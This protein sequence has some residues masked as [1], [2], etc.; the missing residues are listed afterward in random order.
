MNS[1]K[2][3]V[4]NFSGSGPSCSINFSPPT[5]SGPGDPTTA[6]WSSS[7]DADNQIP[8]SCTGNISPG[9]LTTGGSLVVNPT[10][11]QTCTLTVQNSS[12]SNTCQGSVTVGS[13]PTEGAININLNPSSGGPGSS[14]VAAVFGQC[15]GGNEVNV[16]VSPSAGSCGSGS[17][18]SGCPNWRWDYPCVA[19]NSPGSS[20]TVTGSSDGG[21]ATAIYN[22]TGGG[23]GPEPSTADITCSPSTVPYNSSA[24]VSWNSSNVSNCTVSPTGW[25]GTFGSQ[26]TGNLTSSTTYTLTCNP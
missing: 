9:T 10:T 22:V 19:P 26:S 6:T 23:G 20:V 18:Q 7:G 14:Y 2:Y 3:A 15:G 1:N 4:A 5:V 11:S 8:F 12:G 13:T 21:S 25:T 16:G 24:N 17:L